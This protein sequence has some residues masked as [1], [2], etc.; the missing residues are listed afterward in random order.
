[1]G[2][3]SASR[4]NE[5]LHWGHT[6]STY[7]TGKEL[8]MVLDR[9]VAFCARRC[10]LRRLLEAPAHAWT[11]EV[12]TSSVHGFDNPAPKRVGRCPIQPRLATLELP[13]QPAR[14]PTCDYSAPCSSRT[15]SHKMERPSEI[16]AESLSRADS[17]CSAVGIWLVLMESHPEA[18][19]SS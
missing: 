9:G 2:D 13:A 14:N 19:K 18:Q 15:L 4:L 3:G 5:P 17:Q 7:L 10:G 16:C 12:N 11:T 8:Y 1:M 6:W